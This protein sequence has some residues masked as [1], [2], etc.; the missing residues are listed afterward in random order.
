MGAT[1]MG[2]ALHNSIAP[3]ITD[4]F[5]ELLDQRTG[6]HVGFPC[7]S[8]TEDLREML[9]PE[10]YRTIETLGFFE[11]VSI[12]ELRIRQHGIR[13]QLQ[14]D[15]RDD[16]ISNYGE[17][18]T[19]NVPYYRDRL[20]LQPADLSTC[21]NLPQIPVLSRAG[22]AQ[23]F[24]ELL[25]DGVSY[26]DQLGEGRMVWTRT[27][28]TTSERIQVPV[29]LDLDRVPPDYEKIWNLDHG[30]KIPRTAV[31]ATPRCSPTECY[32]STA[33]MKERTRFG[34]TLFMNSHIDIF[35]LSDDVI[36]GFVAELWEFRPDFLLV[37]PTYLQIF[38]SQAKTLDLEIP[39]VE[40]VLSSYQY[41]SNL[42]R[43]VLS[44]L[45]EA[46]VYNIYTATELCGCQLG[47]ECSHGNWHVRED[48]SLL[49]VVDAD[50]VALDGEI[51]NL[52]VTTHANHLLPLLRYRI[53]D[54]GRFTNTACT[55]ELAD[56]Q[57]FELHGRESEALTIQG[58]RITTRQFDAIMELTSGVALYRYTQMDENDLLVEVLP[59]TAGEMS[60]V[61]I[62]KTLKEHL[63]CTVKVEPVRSL[64]AGPSQ[65]F[66]L[67]R[68]A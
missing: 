40:L 61:A 66:Q 20:K 2:T 18:I 8:T 36:R 55:C 58:R 50:G 25:A 17:F 29:D 60:V 9:G 19:G 24:N 10:F 28:G 11:E 68:R 64:D 52:L 49:E 5:V 33:S 57:C 47:V 14:R 63:D 27:S 53:G 4:E 67:T 37:N 44:R 1:Y 6:L 12:P 23:H 48:H 59:D 65:K 35:N 54:L 16:L 38:A 43:T 39:P 22:L 62:T 56:W 7:L 51:G 31:L 3:N 42:Q 46:P 26:A 21:R 15:V 30:D 45:I 41:M 32:L 34:N 13:T